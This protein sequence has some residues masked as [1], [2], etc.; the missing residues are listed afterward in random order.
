MQDYWFVERGGRAALTCLAPWVRHTICSGCAA[1]KLSLGTISNPHRFTILI[2]NC[3]S[4]QLVSPPTPSCPL[5]LLF[6]PT[7]VVLFLVPRG[8]SGV[9]NR[10][11]SGHL[12]FFFHPP[13]F[14]YIYIYK[15]R[16]QE[17][18]AGRSW[19]ES[20]LVIV[21]EEAGE[22]SV[23]QQDR[24]WQRNHWAGVI[25]CGP[26][27]RNTRL[28]VLQYLH[29]SDVSAWIQSHPLLNMNAF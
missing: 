3:F 7:F 25:A 20:N 13:P 12:F 4:P 18:G 22:S 19:Q 6:Y 5:L 16:E 26:P 9:N 27:Y 17:H 24:G 10:Q 2:C 14:L 23:M 21:V 29:P 11:T 15:K 8:N 28:H 1:P